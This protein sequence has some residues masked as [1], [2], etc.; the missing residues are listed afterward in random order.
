L[1]L[2]SQAVTGVL[3]WWNGRAGRG[4]RSSKAGIK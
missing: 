4:A 1:V 3:M 2:A